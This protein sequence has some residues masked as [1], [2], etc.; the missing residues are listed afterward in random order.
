MFEIN[1]LNKSG[2]Q[3]KEK[4]KINQL[5]NKAPSIIVQE[6]NVSEYGN[7]NVKYF[8][9][10]VVMLVLLLFAYVFFNSANRYKADYEDV[11]PGSILSILN[12]YTEYNKIHAIQST[13]NSF[14]II[15]EIPGNSDIYLE[16]KS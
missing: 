8:Y 6:D 13:P 14:Q 1:L 7:H 2:L 16:Q 11:S 3:Y 10:I 4:K 9:Y 5:S 12:T 15:K